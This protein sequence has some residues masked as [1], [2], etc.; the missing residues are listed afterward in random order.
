MFAVLKTER[1]TLISPPEVI[2]NISTSDGF[3]F[4]NVTHSLVIAEER[5]VRPFLGWD[6]YELLLS[7]KNRIV[8]DTNRAALQVYINQVNAGGQPYELKN[9]DIVNAAELMPVESLNLWRQYLCKYIAECVKFLCV[10]E[11][12]GEFSK[13]GIMKNNPESGFMGESHAA[14]SVGIAVNEAKWLMDKL[15]NDRIEPFKQ[16]M[17]TYICRNKSLFPAYSQP[18]ECEKEKDPLPKTSWVNVSIYADDDDDFYHHHRPSQ[19]PQQAPAVAP[20]VT[21]REQWVT[22]PGQ[23]Q[24][25]YPGQFNEDAILNQLKGAELL[26]LTQEGSTIFAGSNM[27]EMQGIDPVTGRITWNTPAPDQEIGLRMEMLYKK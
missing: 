1:Q 13:S 21:Y 9:G 16:A 24:Y 14:R 2:N 6:L 15:I 23:T 19:Q 12:F 4:E 17:H 27:G 5:F 18:C 26:S 20:K 25:P 7:Q 8:D 11:M 10:P 22:I 3:G